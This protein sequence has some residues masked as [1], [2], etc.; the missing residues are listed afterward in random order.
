MRI[1]KNVR[2]LPKPSFSPKV[3]ARV[4]LDRNENPFDLPPGLKKELM[5]E[6]SKIPLNRYPPAYPKELEEK[7]AEFH[8]LEPENVMVANGSDEL[9]GLI[10]KVF[11]GDHI[12]ISS[13]TFGMYGFFATLEGIE[14]V[15]VPLEEDFRL[16]DIEA[17]SENARV[18]FICSPNNPTGNV[19]PRKRIIEVLETG[20]PVVL[21]EA[22][23]EFAG[24]SNTDLVKDYDNLIVL[25]TFSKAFGLAGARIGYAVASEETMD[26][27]RRVLPPFSVSS[28]S[29]RAAEFMLG[30]TDYVNHVIRY[31]IDERERL[32]REFKEYAYPSRANF[33][34]MRL[35]A[36]DFL[37]E[38]GIAVLKLSGRLEGH[39]RVTVG[40]KEENDALI[41]NLKEFIEKE[42]K[43]G[44]G[45]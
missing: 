30:H 43:L 37:L 33:L 42:E 34:L 5:G 11:D 16:G 19:Q 27:L 20:V 28:L 4:R 18:I 41:E 45:D 24:E 44:V 14:T 29:L 31:I 7:I 9:I 3:P 40:K 23:A 21:D 13:P 6:L 26:Y 2:Y 8:G 22:Y 15:D 12:L 38:R 39:I 17:F 1:R 10:L 25:R 32:Y 35:D 36:H